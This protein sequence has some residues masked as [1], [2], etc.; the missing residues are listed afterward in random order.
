MNV[1]K[2]LATSMLAILVLL[3]GAVVQAQKASSTIAPVPV[4]VPVHKRA[5]ITPKLGNAATATLDVQ[6]RM[7][8]FEQFMDLVLADARDVARG[9]REEHIGA[10]PA[11][12]DVGKPAGR[13]TGRAADRVGSR[14]G[15]QESPYGSEYE[16]PLGSTMSGID[17]RIRGNKPRSTVVGATQPGSAGI[18]SS[19]IGM[20]KSSS[21][22][23]TGAWARESDDGVVTHGTT[24]TTSDARTRATVKVAVVAYSGEDSGSLVSWS[25][26]TVDNMGKSTATTHTVDYVGQSPDNPGTPVVTTKTQ[27]RNGDDEVLSE[28]V[29]PARP[30]NPDED[31]PL[32][33]TQVAEGGG[34]TGFEGPLG[35]SCNP[36]TG[37]CG[38]GLKLGSAQVNPGRMDQSMIGTRLRIDPR[39]SVIN[40]DPDALENVGTPD[41]INRDGKGPGA[42]PPK[43]H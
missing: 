10:A 25:E 43:P 19:G 42:K 22:S 40:P 23:T 34:A 21:R 17:G 35:I 39:N 14:T 12:G 31:P 5:V 36:I 28:H 20:G 33:G 32:D 6:R 1:T 13:D 3:P 8:D 4:P 15:D 26:T 2:V 41:P 11:I 37:V 7:R 29:S 24:T 16:N 27:V 18:A 9:L 38:P 30:Y